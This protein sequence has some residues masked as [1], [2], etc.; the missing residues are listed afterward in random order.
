M[1][2]RA[3]S[4]PAIAEELDKRPELM[5]GLE[6]VMRA[7]YDL[8]TDRQIGMAPGPIPFSSIARYGELF[9]MATGELMEFKYMIV[10]MDDAYLEYLSKKN[11]KK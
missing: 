3:E 8:S 10:R 1:E 2:A 5:A 6:F 9:E 11:G 4:S 7:F